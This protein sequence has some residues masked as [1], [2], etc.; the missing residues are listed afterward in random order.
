VISN[1]K[2]TKKKPDQ[3]PSDR[4]D[5][6]KVGTDKQGDKTTIFFTRTS[7]KPGNPL[8]FKFGPSERSVTIN[9]MRSALVLHNVITKEGIEYTL[10][11]SEDLF[12]SI[13]KYLFPPVAAA[14]PAAPAAP[15]AAPV[16]APF[17]DD[18]ED[19]EE[20]YDAPVPVPAPAPAPA[21]AHA[22]PREFK[23]QILPS[24]EGLP[25]GWAKAVDEINGIHY[26]TTTIKDEQ[27][28][29]I[30]LKGKPT[31]SANIMY[32]QY[33]SFTPDEDS[34]APAPASFTSDEDSSA[35]APA[36]PA[37][38]WVEYT[39]EKTGETYYHNPITDESRWDKP[40]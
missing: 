17:A 7:E 26:R 40:Q 12:N 31:N 20:G 5:S 23:V 21:P 6:F 34:S 10:L 11:G 4:D 14:A 18:E 2:Y 3:S 38:D 39:D 24:P 13:K 22:P 29:P 28:K 19:D 30:I 27:G 32:P 25:S 16:A 1:L 35:P 15:V 33:A 37:S 9:Q 36:P 8:Q